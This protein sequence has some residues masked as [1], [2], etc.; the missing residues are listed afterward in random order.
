MNRRMAA[1]GLVAA[2][3]ITSCG[4]QQATVQ[5]ARYEASLT[6]LEGGGHGPQLCM[7]VAESLPPQCGGPDVVGWDWSKVKHESLRGVKWGEYRVVGTWDGAR[8]TLTEPPGEPVRRQEGPDGHDRFASPCPEPAG[9]W[10]PVEPAKTTERTMNEAIERARTAEEFA[11]AWID[12]LGPEPGP[13][14]EE[15]LD[16]RKYVVNLR[17]TGELQGREAWIREVWGGA[18]CVTGA[19]HGEAE[20]QRIQREAE[21]AVGDGLVSASTDEISNQVKVSTWLA[22][23]DLRRTFDQKYGAGVVVFDSV[24]KRVG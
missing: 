3:T 11:G 23:D 5:P 8:L 19:R 14:Q 1:L 7:V 15:T 12:R 4:D 22:G 20:L 17:F 16:A 10:R 21:A 13:E 9:G 18:L 6:V 24:L 2:L